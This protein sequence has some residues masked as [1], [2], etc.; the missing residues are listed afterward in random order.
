MNPQGL[1][2]RDWV[3]RF[4]ARGPDGLLNG[5]APGPQGPENEIGLHLRR[6]LP[7][8]NTKTMSLHLAEIS[9]AIAPALTRSC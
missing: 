8:C 1:I 4:N 5:K 7:F 2:V 9:R 6:D 3:V